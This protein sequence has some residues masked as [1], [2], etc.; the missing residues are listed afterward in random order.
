LVAVVAVPV[1]SV[2][3]QYLGLGAMAVPGQLPRLPIIRPYMPVAAEAEDIPGQPAPE[4]LV[5]A[6]Q[7]LSETAT[8][9]TQ[10][11]TVAVAVVAAAVGMAVP[12]TRGLSSSGTP[13]PCVYSAIFSKNL[14]IVIE[15]L[16]MNSL[17][18]Y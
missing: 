8:L 16:R 18:F 2:G 10:P 1:L 6:A 7:V 5:L 17:V 9:Q 4:V 13:S 3:V 11:I 12:A 15:P 14:C